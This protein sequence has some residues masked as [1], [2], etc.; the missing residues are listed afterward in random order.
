M[1]GQHKSGK[2]SWAVVMIGQSGLFSLSLA[3]VVVNDDDDS[4][5]QKLD[6]LVQEGWLESNFLFVYSTG[7]QQSRGRKRGGHLIEAI[8]FV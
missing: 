4:S 5:G 8:R 2:I 1:L 3:P 7:A 6:D